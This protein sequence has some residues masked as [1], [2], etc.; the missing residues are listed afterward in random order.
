[1]TNLLLAGYT[2][3]LHVLRFHRLGT[4]HCLFLPADWV[5]SV[6]PHGGE[7]SLTCLCSHLINN[8]NNNFFEN[9]FVFHFCLCLDLI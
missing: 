3:T 8:S 6:L 7:Y 1:M 9:C 5:D 2:M 4:E